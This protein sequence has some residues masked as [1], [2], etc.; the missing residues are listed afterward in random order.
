MVVLCAAPAPR[1]DVLLRILMGE[2]AVLV[3]LPQMLGA[4]LAGMSLRHVK[5]TGITHIPVCEPFHDV[6]WVAAHNILRLWPEVV[7]CTL[8]PSPL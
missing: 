7:P 8:V 3:R 4:H 5:T 6:P 2:V 1:I